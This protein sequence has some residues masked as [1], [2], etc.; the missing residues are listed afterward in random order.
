MKIIS[1]NEIAEKEKIKPKKANLNKT[2]NN[3]LE[4]M[5]NHFGKLSTDKL[6]SLLKE[7]EFKEEVS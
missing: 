4:Y 6:I 7:M 3:S 5:K 1:R 2:Y